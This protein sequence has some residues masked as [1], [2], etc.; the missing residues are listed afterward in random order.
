[1]HRSS[2]ARRA[3]NPMAIM[4]LPGLVDAHVHLREPGYTQKEDLLSGTRAALAGGV[5]TVLDMPNT[6]PPTS[7]P[8]AL[9]EKSAL[10]RRRLSAMWA[11]SW[12][13]PA[14]IW[15]HIYPLPSARVA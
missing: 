1:M 5:T 7:T 4:R 10:A 9:Q 11:S 6:L 8:D 13:Q 15:T 3:E 14:P 2:D 12:A